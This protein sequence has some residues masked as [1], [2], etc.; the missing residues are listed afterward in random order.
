MKFEIGMGVSVF[1]A[2]PKDEF[3]CWE[4]SVKNSEVEDE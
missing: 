2:P 1:V 4:W 3:S